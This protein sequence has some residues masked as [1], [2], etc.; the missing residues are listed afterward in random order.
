MKRSLVFS[1]RIYTEVAQG[2]GWHWW[3]IYTA[4]FQRWRQR[5]GQL[6]A[7]SPD[8]IWFLG[9]A[10]GKGPGNA[11]A[12]DWVRENC[13]RAVGGNWDYG[14]GRKQ[15]SADGYFWDQL[16]PERMAYLAQLPPETEAWISGVH[17][18]F[19]HGRPVSPCC[20]R[21]RPR[22]KSPLLPRRRGGLWRPLLCGRHRPFFR[23]LD[24]GYYM[25]T[26]S[27]GNSMGVPRAHFL[28]LEGEMNSREPAPLLA[29]VVTVPYDNEAA[30]QLAREDPNLPHREAYITEVL[31]GVYSR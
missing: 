23:T 30:A 11:A 2:C 26:G 9:D 8:E 3:R 24:V 20:W 29:T 16:G 12:C 6:R 19:F 28:L 21:K 31:T 7:L 25:N 5:T 22:R 13:A 1:K 4:I 15:F 27:V 17:F 18:R 14:I 10:V